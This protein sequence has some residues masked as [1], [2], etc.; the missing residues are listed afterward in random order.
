MG[1]LHLINAE[2]NWVFLSVLTHGAPAAIW[3]NPRLNQYSC[4]NICINLD[5]CKG[6]N[7]VDLI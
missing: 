6:P 2:V 1:I 3:I 4:P 7:I 5:L